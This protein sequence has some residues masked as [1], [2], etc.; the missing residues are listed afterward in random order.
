MEVLYYENLGI[1]LSDERLKKVV[2]ALENN[3]FAGADI[4]KLTETSYYRAKLDY[5]NR[6]LLS[7]GKYRNKMYAL[8]LECIPNHRYEKSR[9]LRGFTIDETKLHVLKKEQDIIENNVTR[10]SFLNN[11]VSEFHLLDKVLSFD[12]IQS[13]VIRQKLP[14]V[15]IGSA[16]SGKTALT[17]EMMKLLK[18]NILYLSLSPYLIKNAASSYYANNYQND[19]QEIDFLSF[20]ELINTLKLVDGNPVGFSVFNNWFSRHRPYT[21]IRNSYKLFEEF[22]GVITGLYIDKAFINRQEYLNLGIRQ[23]IFAQSEREEVYN[24]FEKY[25]QWIGQEKLIDENINSFLHLEFAKPQYDYIII[26]EIQDLTNIQ[27]FLALRMMNERGS[28]IFSGDSNQI[29]HPNYFSWTSLKRMFFQ[30]QISK[31]KIHILRTNYRNSIRVTN[32]ANQ[33]LKIKNLRFGSIDRESNYLIETATTENGEVN[34]L[35]DKPETLKELDDKTRNSANFA[36]LVMNEEDKGQA[37]KYFRSPLVFSIQ[38]AKGLEYKNVIIYNFVSSNEKVFREITDGISKTDI[39]NLTELEYSRASDK[40][41]KSLD[42]YKFYINSLYVAITRSVENVYIIESN[43]KHELFSLIGLQGN[44]DRLKIN[45]QKSSLEDWNREARKLEL[46]GKDEQVNLIREQILNTRKPDWQVITPEIFQGHET[47]AY[48]RQNFNKKSKDIVFDYASVYDKVE[49]FNYLNVLGYAKSFD[50]NYPHERKSIY[51]RMYSTYK[52][53]DEK[54]IHNKIAKYGLN[55][56]DEFNL[57]P[58]MAAAHAGSTKIIKHLLD[59]GADP[60]LTDNYGRNAFQIAL[61]QSIDSKDYIQHKLPAIYEMVS[62]DSIKVQIKDQLV[63]FER[64]KAEYF[65]INYLIALQDA[66][67]RER[68]FYE[69]YGVKAGDLSKNLELFPETIIPEYRKQRTYWSSVLTRNERTTGKGKKILMRTERGSYI[70]NPEMKI[71]LKDRTIPVDEFMQYNAT[72]GKITN[73]N[74]DNNLERLKSDLKNEYKEKT[75][76]LAQKFLENEIIRRANANFER[77]NDL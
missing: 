3:D 61:A 6:L 23:S 49:C 50:E 51:R 53:D 20:Q 63:K 75:H 32:A 69:A 65:L 66:L 46:Q 55:Y 44:N 64:H 28:F 68:K 8:L 39:D 56:R 62:T 13:E 41:D 31:G 70:L 45:E 9:F 42:L 37:R 7:F 71:V 76:R 33:L 48:D 17:L 67:S 16:G 73:N 58:L 54:M 34:F 43:Q 11:S 26:D 72:E 52:S 18:G 36:V 2:A 29:V 14:A 1:K 74:S 57:T 19:S 27:I 25:L 30:E 77:F 5:E 47:K 24:L 40:S 21:S 35:N 22:K 59:I 60:D 15:I 12:Q 4:R 38:E 10:L